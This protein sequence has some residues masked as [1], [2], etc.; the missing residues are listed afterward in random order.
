LLP[1]SRFAQQSQLL[2]QGKGAPR[3]TD[4]DPNTIDGGLKLNL[5]TGP[6]LMQISD[7]FWEG[8]LKFAGHP[9]HIPYSSKACFLVKPVQTL[10]WLITSAFGPRLRK[11]KLQ[12]LPLHF[13]CSSRQMAKAGAFAYLAGEPPS[14][15]ELRRVRKAGKVAP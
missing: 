10:A 8:H 6:N 1:G 12:L 3:L 15:F 2:F 14:L 7:G 4:K 5:G 11:R 13:A 9:A